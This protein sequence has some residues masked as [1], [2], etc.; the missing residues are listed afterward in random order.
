MLKKLKNKILIWFMDTSVYN[1]ILLHIIPYIR[2]SV[3]YTSF[4]GWKYH[5]GY[6]LLEEG[7]IILTQDSKKLT[8]FVIGGEFA[9]AALCMSKDGMFEVAEMTHTHYTKSCFFDLCAEADKVTIIRC[10]DWDKDYIKKV[11]AECKTY[12]DALYDNKF[13]FGVKSLYCSELV[14]QADFE[15]RLK[16]S[17]DDIASIGRQYISPYGLYKAENVK[18]IWESN[19]AEKPATI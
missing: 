12:E 8:T 14:F 15:R 1:Y 11:I 3:Y 19:L 7:D 2:F 6:N 4:R 16:V 10:T 9:H 5:Q 18:I 17:L 13:Q